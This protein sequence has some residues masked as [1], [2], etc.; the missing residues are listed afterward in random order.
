MEKIRVDFYTVNGY[1]SEDVVFHPIY[2]KLPGQ[3][4]VWEE[5]EENLLNSSGTYPDSKSS[6]VGLECQRFDI[7]SVDD[8]ME[9]NTDTE[10]PSDDLSVTDGNEEPDTDVL[11]SKKTIFA[12][13]C[14]PADFADGIKEEIVRCARLA[15]QSAEAAAISS[16]ISGAYPVYKN[17]FESALTEKMGSKKDQIKFS[18]KTETTGSNSVGT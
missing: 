14:Y 1:R 15:I 13:V 2:A 4:F 6:E 10:E 3:K 8:W 5:N 12:Q 7:A 17:A 11:T 9:T 16:G 18:L